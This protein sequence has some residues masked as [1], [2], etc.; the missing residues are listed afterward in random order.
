MVAFIVTE[1][2][3]TFAILSQYFFYLSQMNDLEVVRIE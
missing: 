3:V 1:H 2:F